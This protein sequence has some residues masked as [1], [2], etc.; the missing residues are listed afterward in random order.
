MDGWDAHVVVERQGDVA[1]VYIDGVYRTLLDAIEHYHYSLFGSGADDTRAVPANVSEIR[2]DSRRLIRS[3][4][5][6]LDANAPN[7]A[8]VRSQ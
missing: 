5:C 2:D 6:P 3:T 4:V 8:I 1:V 7:G